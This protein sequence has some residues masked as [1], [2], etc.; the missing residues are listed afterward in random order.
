MEDAKSDNRI[1]SDNE[2]ISGDGQ[3]LGG[4]GNVSVCGMLP[5]RAPSIVNSR[6]RRACDSRLN[7]CRDDATTHINSKPLLQARYFFPTTMY[8]IRRGN[9]ASFTWQFKK[10]CSEAFWWDDG[11]LAS[12][13]I[14]PLR[15]RR[16]H[17]IVIM[18]SVSH[19]I[20]PVTR[21]KKSLFG[22]ELPY[23]RFD[24]PVCFLD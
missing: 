18:F 2:I 21:K 5:G 9:I 3:V 12:F 23:V 4:M 6:A 22:L 8:P 24:L 20:Q 15:E 14:P 19:F 13:R 7:G 10:R 11:E 16:A 17:R 1:Q